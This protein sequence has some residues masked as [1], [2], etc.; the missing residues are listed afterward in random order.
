MWQKLHLWMTVYLLCQLLKRS[1][2]KMSMKPT[3]KMTFLI[4]RARILHRMQ[5]QDLDG[6]YTPTSAYIY[7]YVNIKQ[8]LM[9]KWHIIQ[10]QPLLKKIFKDPPTIYFKNG[11]FL[12]DMLVRAK[13]EKVLKCF[14]SLEIVRPVTPCY[15][16]LKTKFAR[17]GWHLQGSLS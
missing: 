12:K 16:F 2:R 6:Q 17:E 3:Q 10:E 8:I 14:T 7:K 5:F 9:K 11:K 15:L 1:L 13:I 4:R